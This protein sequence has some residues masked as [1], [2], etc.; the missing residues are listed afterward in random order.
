MMLNEDLQVY[1]E[2]ASV[3]SN[4]NEINNTETKPNWRVT[5]KSQEAKG[6]TVRIIVQLLQASQLKK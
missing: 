2:L 6:V 3:N 5:N 4:K 1:M